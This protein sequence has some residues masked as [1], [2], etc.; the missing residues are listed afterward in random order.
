[1]EKTKS[2]GLVSSSRNQEVPWE[3]CTR[4]ELA[5]DARVAVEVKEVAREVAK[6]VAREAREE[7]K[8]ARNIEINSL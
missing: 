6:E 5:R 2:I 7:R 1:M 4:K 8:G 3:N